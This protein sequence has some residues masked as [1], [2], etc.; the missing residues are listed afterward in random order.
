MTISEALRLAAQLSVVSDSP[1]LDAELLLAAVSGFDR[2]YFY[3]WPE[4]EL[5]GAVAERFLTLL[6]RREAGEPVAHITGQREFWS[7]NLAIDSSTLIPRPDTEVLVEVALEHLPEGAA[8]VLDLGTGSGAIALALATERPNAAVKGV[9]QSADAVA[10]AKT[11]AKRLGLERVHFSQGSWLDAAWLAQVACEQPF[12]LLVSN[13]PYIDENDPHLS[14]GDVRFEPKAALVAP[15]QGL[16]DIKAIIA[17]AL[18]IVKPTGSL[19]LEHGWQQAVD[20][21]R[22]LLAAGFKHVETRKDYGGNPRVTGAY[23]S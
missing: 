9:D 22:L 2:T 21:Q 8:R 23:R 3:T 6:K 5:D 1:R 12:D 11:N 7:L 16:A 19:W 4:R 15:E 17:L 10:L 20:V 18:N 14:E 13:P